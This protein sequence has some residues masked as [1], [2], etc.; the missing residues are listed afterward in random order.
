MNVFTASA[1][2]VTPDTD[3]DD[4]VVDN[5]GDVGI[6]L[7]S[8][9]ANYSRIWFNHPSGGS[10]QIRYSNS[11]QSMHF[12]AGSNEPL[13]I[14]SSGRIGIGTAT[15]AQKLDIYTADAGLPVMTMCNTSGCGRGLGVFAGCGCSNQYLMRVSSNVGGGTLLFTGDGNLGIGTTA[16]I[17][18]NGIPSLDIYKADGTCR[19]TLTPCML[20]FCNTCQAFDGATLG[21][22]GF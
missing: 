8:P 13:N 7:I 16:P 17:S 12:K 9:D 21:G 22:I 1:G 2:S 11:T 14:D 18:G 6:Q 5:S 15:M 4:L 10:A 19:V 3:A 20:Q